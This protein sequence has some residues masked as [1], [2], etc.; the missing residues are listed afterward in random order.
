MPKIDRKQASRS[1]TGLFSGDTE[2]IFLLQRQDAGENQKHWKN[3]IVFIWKEL[4]WCKHIR[5][6][7]QTMFVDII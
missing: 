3:Q 6:Q 2:N 5:K 4:I 7:N 1:L